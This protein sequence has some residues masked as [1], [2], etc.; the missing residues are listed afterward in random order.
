MLANRT[1][2]KTKAMTT[3]DPEQIAFNDDDWAVF[4]RMIVLAVAYAEGEGAA[5]HDTV[6]DA[7]DILTR[8]KDQP[9]D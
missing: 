5:F 9:N 1:V 6:R 7:R 3:P 2:R 8:L 4:H